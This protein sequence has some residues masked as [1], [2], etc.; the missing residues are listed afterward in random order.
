L[1]A[2]GDEEFADAI[3]SLLDDEGERRRLGRRAHT[4]A[5]RELSWRSMADRYDDLYERLDGGTR[6]THS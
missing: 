1:I 4:W 3:S 2:D 5:A 6:R